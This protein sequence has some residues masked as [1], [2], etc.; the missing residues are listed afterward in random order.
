MNGDQPEV[1]EREQSRQPTKSIQDAWNTA[2]SEGRSLE[3]G[4]SR[5]APAPAQLEHVRGL[6][7]GAGWAQRSGEPSNGR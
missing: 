3:E 6:G 4:A 1:K 5:E 2:R 7:R